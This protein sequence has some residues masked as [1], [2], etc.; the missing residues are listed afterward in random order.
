M[1]SFLP[2]ALRVGTEGRD[3]DRARKGTGIHPNELRGHWPRPTTHP[4]QQV[5]SCS[6]ELHR[7]AEGGRGKEKGS[8]PHVPQGDLE[9]GLCSRFC[10]WC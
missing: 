3:T 8:S 1:P 2:P 10:H 9:N 7:K 4:S 6:Q 5:D